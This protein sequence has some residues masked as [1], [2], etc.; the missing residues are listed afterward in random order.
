MK[1]DILV[2][3]KDKLGDMIAGKPG[4]KKFK[5]EHIFD[6]I[7][8]NGS[9]KD[10]AKMETD[11]NYKQIIPYIVMYNDQAQI[12]TLKRLTTQSEKRL[13]NKISLGVGGHVNNL[14]SPNPLEAFKAGMKREI[15]EEVNVTMKSDPEFLGV[16]DDETTD[17]GKVHLGLAYKVEIEF[18]GINEKDKFDYSWKSPEELNKEINDM[19]NWSIFVLKAL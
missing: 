2:I 18:N 10:R 14:D 19:E 7:T 16:I 17:V 11:R 4:L 8:K 13:H 9:F 12:L 6:L 3:P 5:K 1:E 15:E